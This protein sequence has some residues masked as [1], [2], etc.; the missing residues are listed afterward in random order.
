MTGLVDLLPFWLFFVGT[1][2]MV[3]VP[4]D[5]GRRLG[6]HRRAKSGQE[7]ESTTSIISAGLVSLN[8]FFLAFVFGMVSDRYESRQELVREDAA[9]IRLAYLHTDLLDD[10]VQ[11]HARTLLR[12][13][14]A[15]RILAVESGD[16]TPGY[17]MK[18]RARLQAIQRDLWSDAVAASGASDSDNV[19]LYLDSLENLI[20]VDLQR[21]AVGYQSRLPV[22]VWTLLAALNVLSMFGIGFLAGNSGSRHSVLTPALALAFATIVTLIAILDRPDGHVAISQQPLL[23]LQDY[24]A[25]DT[26]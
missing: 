15:Q 11:S 26:R 1:M 13:Y 3:L 8:S 6:V 21:W 14:L 19:P 9:S 24:L 25:T 16:V 23:D 12:E 10:P 22:G 7:R 20:D 17:V 2:A 4:I 5:A 18:E